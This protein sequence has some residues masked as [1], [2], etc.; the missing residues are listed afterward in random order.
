MNHAAF[1]E[2]VTEEE[3]ECLRHLTKLEVEDADDIKSGSKISFYFAPNRFFE[4]TVISKDFHTTD[5]EATCET[6][7]IKWKID[8]PRNGKKDG[9]LTFFSW[10]EDNGTDRMDIVDTIREDIWP[11]PI[12]YFAVSLDSRY[13]FN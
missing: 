2:I 5:Y 13:L 1:A 11:N 7:E 4:N 6:T 9:K 8:R 10:L 12:H 3:E